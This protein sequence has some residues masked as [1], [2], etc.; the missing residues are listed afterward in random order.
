MWLMRAAEIGIY[1]WEYDN[2]A[3]IPGTGVGLLAYS[4]AYKLD[5]PMSSTYAI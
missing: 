3:I 1:N 5:M 2:S 4:Q